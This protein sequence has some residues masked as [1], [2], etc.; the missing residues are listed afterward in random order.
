M[1]ERRRSLRNPANLPLDLYDL[2]GNAIVGEGRI[3]NLSEKGGLLESRKPLKPHAKIRIHLGEIKN[4][5]LQL[6]GKVIWSKR[7]PRG[8]TYGIEFLRSWSPRPASN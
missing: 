3:R 6:A 1:K 8:F 4:S 7:R 2:K 5:P